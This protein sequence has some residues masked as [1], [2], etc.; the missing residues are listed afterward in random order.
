MLNATID[1]LKE[2]LDEQESEDDDVDALATQLGDVALTDALDFDARLSVEETVL[3]ERGLKLLT[4]TCA[5]LKRGVL[6]LKK[7]TAA[8]ADS[9]SAFL[10]W[11]AQLDRSYGSV[12]DPIVDMG[13]ALYPPIDLEELSAAVASVEHASVEVLVTL[14][15]EPKVTAAATSELERGRSAFD[16]QVATVKAQIETSR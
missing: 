7:Y 2:L 9:D 8:S 5:V 13:A 1:E 6:A 12:K 10:Q 3:F 16:Q 15:A 11:T 14:L 4:M